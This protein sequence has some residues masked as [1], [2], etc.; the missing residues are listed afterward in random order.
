M[1]KSPGRYGPEFKL[2]AVQRLLAGERPRTVAG[3]LKIPEGLLYD[4]R[5]AYRKQGAA[6]LRM[7]GRPKRSPAGQPRSATN[8]RDERIA[9]LERKIGRQQLV[10]DF[11]QAA[12]RRVEGESAPTSS[13]GASECIPS[14]GSVPQCKAE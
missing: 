4:W 6:G 13:V 9:E 10:I 12:L 2:A 8:F 5:A 7:L 14:C 3:E 11:L 1:R